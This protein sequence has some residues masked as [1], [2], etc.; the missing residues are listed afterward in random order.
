ML[1]TLG[2]A[3]NPSRHAM[4]SSRSALDETGV[5]ELSVT[6]P[7]HQYDRHRSGDGDGHR[8]RA[9][10]PGGDPGYKQAG[11]AYRVEGDD[12]SALDGVS[13]PLFFSKNGAGCED[14]IVG[15]WGCE[16]RIATHPHGARPHL[17]LPGQR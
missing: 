7:R 10:A 12:V 17:S 11:R 2:G 5:V 14:A 16:G 4:G 3:A 9:T 1:H 15:H 8:Q 6:A 13:D